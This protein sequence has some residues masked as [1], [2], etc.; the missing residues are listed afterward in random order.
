MQFGAY[1]MHLKV[2]ERKDKKRFLN[3]LKKQFGF[4]ESLDYAFLVNNKFKVFIVNK[5]ITNIDLSKLRINSVGLY[6]AEFKNEEIR[7]TIEGSQIIGPKAN[8]NVVELNDKE[9]RDWLKG[10][11]LEKEVPAKGFIIL[12]NNRDFLGSGR[13]KENTILNFVPKIRRLNVSD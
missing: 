2:M 6:F 8:K 12:K 3:L 5:D 7:P 11:D 4:E 1:K 13:I 9:T 10:K